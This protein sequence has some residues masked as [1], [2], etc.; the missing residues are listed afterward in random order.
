M[1]RSRGHGFVEFILGSGGGSV[2]DLQDDGNRVR[3][4]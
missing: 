4:I 1:G 3:T 2:E